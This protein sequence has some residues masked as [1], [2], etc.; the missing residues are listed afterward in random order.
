M[1]CGACAKK[2]AAAMAQMTQQVLPL[3]TNQENPDNPG[4]NPDVAVRGFTKKRYIGPR[5]RLQSVQESLSYGLRNP[6]EV[7]VI[8]QI[9]AEAH[10]EWWEDV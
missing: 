8:L 4:P 5:Q 1:A 2:R 9:D 6:G 3:A 7:L 10:P